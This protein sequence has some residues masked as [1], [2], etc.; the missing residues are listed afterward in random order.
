MA[1]LPNVTGGSNPY[2]SA[3]LT[4]DAVFAHAINTASVMS[5]QQSN[6]G[7]SAAYGP[8]APAP[9]PA[10]SYSAHPYTATSASRG[11]PVSNTNKLSYGDSRSSS[12]ARVGNAPRSYAASTAS[13]AGAG[14]TAAGGSF[15]F[16]SSF[17]SS[18]SSAGKSVLAA[19]NRY[20][21]N[22]SGSNCNGN[23][24]GWPT[25]GAIPTPLN[26]LSRA[27]LTHMRKQSLHQHSVS[28]GTSAN[29]S[30]NN[31]N[32]RFLSPSL[33]ANSFSNNTG[34]GSSSANS[35]SIATPFTLDTARVPAFSL[36]PVSLRAPLRPWFLLLST[37]ACAQ[38]LRSPWQAPLLAMHVAARRIQR[39]V[40]R[41]RARRL[42]HVLVTHVAQERK[43]GFLRRKLPLVAATENAR[44]AAYL[45]HN[46]NNNSSSNSNAYNGGSSGV[47][48]LG[49]SASASA[50]GVSVSYA[51][52]FYPRLIPPPLLYAEPL[53]QGLHYY[54]HL[55]L[56]MALQQQQQQQLLQGLG[57]GG[58]VSASNVSGMPLPAGPSLQVSLGYC[59]NGDGGT[60]ANSGHYV[61]PFQKQQQK[62]QLQADGGIGAT[63]QC[64]NNC[65]AQSLQPQSR[66]PSQAPSQSPCTAVSHY[67]FSPQTLCGSSNANTVTIDTSNMYINNNVNSGSTQNV[68]ACGGAN[69]SAFVSYSGYASAPGPGPRLTHSALATVPLTVTA[70][71][72]HS[73]NIGNNSKDNNRNNVVVSG[74]ASGSLCSCVGY[75]ATMPFSR[76][77]SPSAATT[78]DSD[79]G[80]LTVTLLP[81]FCALCTAVAHSHSQQAHQSQQALLAALALPVPPPYINP[82]NNN[83]YSNANFT[84]NSRSNNPQLQHQSSAFN[85]QAASIA[86]S[87]FSALPQRAATLHHYGVD[88]RETDC[89]YAAVF[90]AE[91]AP[92]WGVPWPPQAYLPLSQSPLTNALDGHE[93]NS[94]NNS[95]PNIPDQSNNNNNNANTTA[96]NNGAMA[97]KRIVLAPGSLSLTRLDFFYAHPMYTVAAVSL[98]RA[99]RTA[100]AR[101]SAR[102]A[103][104]PL[105]L[106]VRAARKI[107]RAWRA[108]CDKRVYR[109]FRDLALG[110]RLGDTLALLR[111]LNP[112]EAGLVDG[113]SGVYVRFRLAGFPPRLYYKLYTARPV[114]DVGAFA[115]RNY[116]AIAASGAASTAGANSNS[117]T[118][119]GK[120]TAATGANA[121]SV[122]SDP[123]KEWYLRQDN[124]NWR[125]VA[126]HHIATHLK[127][128]FQSILLMT[129]SAHSAAAAHHRAYYAGKAGEIVSGNEGKAMR[130]WA[131][132]SHTTN[133]NGKSTRFT[134][135]AGSSDTTVGT[136]TE[137]S[138]LKPYHPDRLVRQWQ[139]VKARKRAKLRWLQKLFLG[140]GGA[141]G[142]V[143][144]PVSNNSDASTGVILS[145]QSELKPQGGAGSVS[146]YVSAKGRFNGG[147]MSAN[148]ASVYDYGDEDEDEDADFEYDTSK[149][150]RGDIRIA[151]GQFNPY[152]FF[153]TNLITTGNA[154]STNTAARGHGRSAGASAPGR[155]V[156]TTAAAAAF[157]T[158]AALLSNA[159]GSE[160]EVL[161]AAFWATLDAAAQKDATVALSKRVNAEKAR[162]QQQP[163]Q[164]AQLQQHSDLD[165]DLLGD[166]NGD[167]NGNVDT[168]AMLSWARALDYD[169]YSSGWGLAATTRPAEE[170][171]PQMK[172]P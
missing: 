79:T 171:Q 167:G 75:S 3:D 100:R 112:R 161:T 152:E 139:A 77:Q 42:L 12:S 145:A 69:V 25:P 143:I 158:L 172:R 101:R 115:P 168:E 138:A 89:D 149:R 81:C 126:T 165:S 129:A 96:M 104:L 123:S 74:N 54:D 14:S 78:S 44:E 162:Q 82:Y 80:T 144:V 125:P 111:A 124:N 13:S 22:N 150:D 67:H 68:N 48:G 37:A 133:G 27:Q 45:Q 6:T 136:A 38:L 64:L 128:N 36:S 107:Q 40:R 43:T 85:L 155:L 15:A 7:A 121:V 65:Y 46:N 32:W 116:A 73:L 132:P 117:S 49:A 34:A 130:Q 154:D 94:N 106:A 51:N 102:R 39:C 153:S 135:T 8:A 28:N 66:P 131:R 90:T 109:Y 98:Q 105:L 156:V 160:K 59:S 62:L 4:D 88:L 2:I 11:N 70:A 17:L 41:W 55:L 53:P 87:F 26:A 19:H 114:T 31:N 72:R 97:T 157:P 164:R 61:S 83:T 142:T 148:N 5:P 159:T 60:G 1:T 76:S 52:T 119:N 140:R 10:G 166:M 24:A 134:S 163:Q 86:S 99:W 30:N 103:R 71:A 84:N 113:A 146:G 141:T 47:G 18:L 33:P 9:V 50:G 151:P 91:S 29:N 110:R 170:P 147:E 63:R 92:Q 108:Y 21:T 122:A 169:S 58:N 56:T 95:D 23:C 93:Q 118:N 57:H 35:G 137:V 20:N 16:P 120:T 127:P